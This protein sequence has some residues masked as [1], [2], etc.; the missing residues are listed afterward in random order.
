MNAPTGPDNFKVDYSAH[1]DTYRRDGVVII[2]GALDDAQMKRVEEAFEARLADPGPH[3]EHIFPDDRPVTLQTVGISADDPIIVPLLRHTAIADIAQSL[4]GGAP[5]WYMQD[6]LWMKE[7]GNARRTPWHQDSSYFPANGL[8]SVV[9]WFC[10]DPV[11]RVN[12]LEVVRGSHRGPMYNGSLLDPADPTEP[13]YTGSELPRLPDI[14]ADRSRW[15]IVSADMERGDV[16]VFNMNS[17][18]GG[19]PTFPGQR[20]RTL[21]FRFFGPDYCF[22]TRPKIRTDHPMAAA[23]ANQ[24]S[25]KLSVGFQGLSVGD[26]IGKSAFFKKVRDADPGRRS[27]SG[28]ICSD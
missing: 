27:V 8:D 11:A 1:A 2:H 15:D 7:G 4:L 17:L 10:M 12:C 9:M 18:H 19:A 13:L 14:E 20:R 16:L 24:D 28:H 5:L 3:A 23:R 25:E 26:P 21:S 6:Q 22:G